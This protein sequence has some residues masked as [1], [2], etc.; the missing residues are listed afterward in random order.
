MTGND[1]DPKRWF[2]CGLA[3]SDRPVRLVCFPHAGASAF[4]FREWHAL[5]PASVG[6]VPMQLPG[7]GERLREAPFKRLG[8]LLRSV[9]AALLPALD[10][11]F[12]LFGHS[13]GALIAF[14]LAR[15]LEGE[16]GRRP[17]HLFV[18][19]RGA[20]DLPSPRG[21]I[22]RL[23]PAA[24]VMAL[25][26]YS[27]SVRGLLD[28]PEAMELFLPIL[29]AD[30]ELAETYGYVP[31]PPLSCPITVFGGEED[32]TV[33]PEQ[34]SGWRR[35]TVRTCAIHMLPG[36]HFFVITAHRDVVGT[37]AEA[38]RPTA[39]ELPNE[40]TSYHSLRGRP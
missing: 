12:A 26:E 4:I 22:H 23:P 25:C 3:P 28:D 38:L 24:F 10:R 40:A 29:R 27:R 14:E 19:G 39:S 30:L 16:H 15:L 9:C 21:D 34:L 36:D 18:S 35:Q 6:V 37:I 20:P 2:E 8:P 11:P 32:E 7:H 31:R 5:M 13:V 1:T 33:P 17:E